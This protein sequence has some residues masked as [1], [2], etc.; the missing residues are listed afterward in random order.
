MGERWSK[1]RVWEWYNA[2]PWI[3][4]CNYMSADCA[5]R[6]DQWQELGFEEKLETTEK[7]FQLM[8]ETGFNTIRII[9][10]FL[11]WDEQHDGFMERFERYISLAAKYGISC[12][13]VLCNDC[14][15]PKSIENSKIGPQT[16]DIG[17]HGGRKL[18][19]HGNLGE[20]GFHVLDEP[21]TR[22]RYL[23]MVREIVEIYK[24]DELLVT[25]TSKSVCITD[26]I[27]IEVAREQRYK[28]LVKGENFN[29]S[30]FSEE[31]VFLG[32]TEPPE[33]PEQPNEAKTLA[34]LSV[35]TLT[36]LND[37]NLS[38]FN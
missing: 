34:I 16:V 36:Q 35:Y 37:K 9:P 19:Q 11:V 1:E 31:L 20:M 23:Q 38:E 32:S 2:R 13:V 17:Y 10:E 8:K 3:R 6:I 29:N 33:E 7:E 27:P 18:S 4:G 22:E 24:N 25:T 15:R 26:Y 5:N 21:E 28:V 12:M 30:E 14:M